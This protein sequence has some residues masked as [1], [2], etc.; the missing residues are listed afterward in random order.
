MHHNDAPDLDPRTDITD[1]FVFQKP[2]DPTRSILILNVYPE[3]PDRGAAFDPDASYELKI[4]TNGDAEAD[5]AFHV[6]FT[7]AEAGRQTAT[8]YHGTD[9]AARD[10][11]R[12]GETI[13][14]CAAVSLDGTVQITAVGDYRFYAGLRGDPFFADRDGFINNM[15][16]TR[17]DFFAD[18]NVLGIVLEVPN[19]PFGSTP[20]VGIWAR[21]MILIHGMLA[22]VNQ[23]GRPGNNIF[24]QGANTFNTIPPSQQRAT[25]LAQ[26]ETMFRSFGYDEHEAT[27]LAAEWVPDILPYHCTCAEGFP[28][29]RKL[30]DDV[31]ANTVHL[32]TKGQVKAD[33][34]HP[35]ADLLPDFPYLGQPHAAEAGSICGAERIVLWNLREGISETDVQRIIE[36]GRDILTHIPSVESLSFGSTAQS[37]ARYQYYV[38][39]CFRDLEAVRDYD[40]DPAHHQYVNDEF[41]PIVADEMVLTYAML[42]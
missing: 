20:Q 17:R 37:G 24:R 1:L 11:G 25:F 10:A 21:T 27:A 9:L 4:D 23:A 3:A 16:W 38:R 26:F 22:P 18:K 42:F 39:M 36:H 14:D 8:V 28:N 2:G 35:H 5:V 15:Q 32:L 19:R 30:T 12:I 31:A 13:V 40:A 7:P 6:L 33:L 34:L 41:A 29:G